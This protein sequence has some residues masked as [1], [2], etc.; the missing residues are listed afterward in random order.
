MRKL[1]VSAGQMDVKLGDFKVN[2]ERAVKLI[3]SA[4]ERGSDLLV[5]P[6]MWPLGFDYAGMQNL[7]PSFLSD[8]ISLLSELSAKYKMHIVSGTMCE[9][10]DGGYFNTAY[11]FDEFGKIAGTYRKVHL[12]K[13]IGEQDFFT[14]GSEVVCVQTAIA[15]ISMAICYDIRFPELFRDAALLGAEI[16]CVPAQFPHPR[17]DHWETLLKARAIEEQLF[18]VAANRVGATGKAEYFGRSMI[19]GPYGETAIEAGDKEEL[20]TEIIDIEKLY[21]VRKVLPALSARRPEVYGNIF[22]RTMP[23]TPLPKISLEPFTRKESPIKFKNTIQ[24]MKP[25]E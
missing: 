20:I 6:E 1:T 18:V 21:E 5:L 9:A 19:V 2:L 16:I 17:E 25:R 13:E 3:E 7:P 24:P 23:P 22:S 14:A 8:I 11:L 10:S 12:F 4:G 15:K